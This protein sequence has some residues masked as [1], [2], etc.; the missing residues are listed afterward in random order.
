MR[1]HALHRQISLESQE[2]SK[3]L[4]Y[5]GDHPSE[6]LGEGG[7]FAEMAEYEGG[8]WRR[9]DAHASAKLNRPMVRRSFAPKAMPV[10][11]LFLPSLS[12]LFGQ[13]RSK[14]EQAAYLAGILAY[15]ALG[16]GDRVMMFR[17]VE[18]LWPWNRDPWRVETFL[19]KMLKENLPPLPPPPSIL[20]PVVWRFLREPCLLFLIGDFIE[21]FIGWKNPPLSES[22]ALIV[23]DHLEE[24]PPLLPLGAFF[25]PKG[26]V[27]EGAMEVKGRD[28]FMRLVASE[29]EKERERLYQSGIKPIKSY[30]QDSPLLALQTLFG[31]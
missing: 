21:P 28:S 29:D 22:Y 4:R 17:G 1:N 2:L 15:S 12:L 23:R 14:L 19:E 10:A 8:D 31:R 26:E 5:F 20:L 24:S 30:T 3:R 27:V 13:D 18:P 16:R 9:V 7:E 11:I 25:D 6:S